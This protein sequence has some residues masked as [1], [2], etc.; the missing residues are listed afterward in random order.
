MRHRS[1]AAGGLL[2]ALFQR[3][4]LHKRV[5]LLQQKIIA[6]EA[7]TS[8]IRAPVFLILANIVLR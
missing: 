4:Q 6:G 8:L 2:L 5:E 7:S 1:G 3:G